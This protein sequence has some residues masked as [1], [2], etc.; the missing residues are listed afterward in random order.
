MN[1]RIHVTK[2][3]YSI[4][5]HQIIRLFNRT[6]IQKLVCRNICFLVMAS[7]TGSNQFLDIDFLCNHKIAKNSL[8]QM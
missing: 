5:M 1:K 7:V 2:N 8:E 4:T 6:L 3:M